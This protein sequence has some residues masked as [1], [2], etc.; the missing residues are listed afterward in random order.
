MVFTAAEVVQLWAHD[1]PFPSLVVLT[2][3]ADVLKVGVFM[4]LGRPR[5]EE[6]LARLGLE[7][8]RKRWLMCSESYADS[9]LQARRDG[10]PG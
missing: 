4:V 2:K 5:L 8:I 6:I 3:S 7:P 1:R 9:G 10:S